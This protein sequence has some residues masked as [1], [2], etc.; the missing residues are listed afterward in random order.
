[1]IKYLIH[2]R[3][4]TLI[5]LYLEG[6]IKGGGAGGRGIS[7]LV[8]IFI[9]QRSAVFVCLTKSRKGTRPIIGALLQDVYSFIHDN[10]H[11]PLLVRITSSFKGTHPSSSRF[12]DRLYSFAL[13]LS[14]MLFEDA[15]FA[16]RRSNDASSLRGRFRPGRSSRDS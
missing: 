1:M 6:R 13:S 15:L 5:C 4:L 12:P 14:S 8:S 11:P 2:F 3:S 7:A 9:H 10:V 16:S